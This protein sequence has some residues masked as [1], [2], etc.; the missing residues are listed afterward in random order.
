MSFTTFIQNK[1]ICAHLESIGFIT[2]TEIQAKAFEHLQNDTDKD[3][4]AL[5]ATGTGKTGAFA[6]PLIQRIELKNKKT[7]ALILC[8]TR[9]L[10]VQIANDIELFAK[11]LESLSSLAVYGGTPIDRQIKRLKKGVHIVIATPGRCL[12]LI[13]RKEI[14]PSEISLVV[15]D[16]ADEMLNMGFKEDIDRILSKLPADKTFWLYSATMSKEVKKI[17]LNYMQDPVEIAVGN[18][19]KTAKNI[20]HHFYPIRDRDRFDALKRVI[21]AH[22]NIFGIVFCRTKRD[23]QNV[24]E[25]LLENG[26]NVAALHGDLNQHQRDSVM[27]S[28][29]S[30]A[31]QLII[32]TDVAARGIDVDDITH[33]IHYQLPDDT[34][35]YT[36]RSGRTA[37]AGKKG[38]S[39]TFISPRDQRKLYVLEKTL[40]FSFIKQNVPTKTEISEKQLLH[41]IDQI[42]EVEVNQ[43]LIHPFLVKAAKKLETFTSEEIIE[44]FFAFY[45]NKNL[46]Y[47]RNTP[48]D[49]TGNEKRRNDRQRNEHSKNGRSR[50]DRSKKSRS[51]SNFI[52]LKLMSGEKDQINKGML[53]RNFCDQSGLSSKHLGK[54]Q[55]KTKFSTIEIDEKKAAKAIA[56]LKKGLRIKSK[57]VPLDF[58]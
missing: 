8:P 37:R 50:F 53:I 38:I 27:N 13:K 4:I 55:I 2:P 15:F 46:E 36:H 51:N 24:S 16:E 20:E 5:A 47:Y 41:L 58:L 28:F 10:C 25:K 45:F 52:T 18:K 42:T 22:P 40:A 11:P 23:C 57:Q 9:E 12:D 29:R 44:R 7:Q 56:K 35:S 33:V 54:I 49:I 1:K 17:A 32:A 19:N 48:E 14:K 34:E 21:D 26:F 3:L 43:K 6:L 31:L 39:L 30:R